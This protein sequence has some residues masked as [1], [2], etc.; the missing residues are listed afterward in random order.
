MSNVLDLFDQTVFLGERATG[1]TNLLQCVWIYDRAIDI[2]GLRQFHRHLQQ[3]R[4]SRRVER[5]ALPFGR[6][7]WVSPSGQ[8]DLEIVATPRPRE[9]FDAWLD[10]QAN[11]PLDAE[12]GPG[13]H[14]AMLAVHRWRRRGELGHLTLPYRRRRVV[15]GVGG[16]GFRPPRPDQLA[17]CRVTPAVA[18]TARRRPPNRARRPRYRPSRRRRSAICPASQRRCR[19]SHSTSP[20]LSRLRCP[21]EQTNASLSRRQRSSSTPM[22]GMPAQSR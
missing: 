5:S 13:W 18:G 6:H 21:R 14:L 9:E 11:T 10:E 1:A 16:R 2:D 20:L 7:R 3:G 19:I 22:T 4:L 8:S 15:R 17:R 12:H